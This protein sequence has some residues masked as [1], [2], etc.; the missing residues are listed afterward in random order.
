MMVLSAMSVQPIALAPRNSSTSLGRIT[1]WTSLGAEENILS[2]WTNMTADRYSSAMAAQKT[3]ARKIVNSIVVS[4]PRAP[5]KRPR[6]CHAA[7]K[8]RKWTIFTMPRRSETPML[9]LVASL[10]PSLGMR[11]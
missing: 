11:L 10:R 6:P 9:T 4:F 8:S 1:S 3:I 5:Y 2:F 7:H